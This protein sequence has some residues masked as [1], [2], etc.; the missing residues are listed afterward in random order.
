MKLTKLSIEE[1]KE[2]A[3][4]EWQHERMQ[5]YLIK[6]YDFYKTEDGIIIEVQKANSLSINKTIWYDDELPKD[7]IPSRCLDNFIWENQH[8]CNRFDCYNRE[9]NNSTKFYFCNQGNA[10]SYIDYDAFRTG[11]VRCVIREI[12]KEE[13]EDILSIYKEQKENY[14]KR[15][16]K[17]FK[18]YAAYDFAFYTYRHISNCKRN[19]EKWKF[20]RHELRIAQNNNKYNRRFTFF[21]H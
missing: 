16:E 12:T 5:E 19:I 20:W 9:F 15:L 10:T 3:R 7:E 6:K 13:M 14:I 18:R 17:Y 2:L 4:K 8:N 1:A 11:D 21:M